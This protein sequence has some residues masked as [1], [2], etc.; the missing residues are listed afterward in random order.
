MLINGDKKYGFMNIENEMIRTVIEELLDVYLEYIPF[1]SN[2]FITDDAKTIPEGTHLQ[3]L[4]GSGILGYVDGEKKFIIEDKINNKNLFLAVNWFL[5]HNKNANFDFCSPYSMRR[6]IIA[7]LE[8]FIVLMEVEDERG[9]S[10]SQRVASLF[11]EFATTL[12]LE[13]SERK[14]FIHY[15]MLHDVGRIGVE[16]LML[17]SPTRLRTFEETG[18]DHTITGSVYISTLEILNDFVPYVRSHHERFDGKGFPDGLK[19][20]EIPFWVRVL[21]IVNWYDNAL[22]TVDSEFSVGV[23]KPEEALEIIANDDGKLFD[24]VLAGKFCKFMEEKIRNEKL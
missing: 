8:P 16:Q 24:P 11:T 9:Y 21:S 10:H 13:E 1:P 4:E 22:N 19:G 20:E 14:L 2:S 5:E 6:R 15:A 18:Q 3:I 23:M 7:V 17:Y 12:G